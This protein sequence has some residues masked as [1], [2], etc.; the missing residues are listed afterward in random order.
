VEGQTSAVRQPG[1]TQSS[2]QIN[3]TS[4]SLR[5]PFTAP[6]LTRPSDILAADVARLRTE[7]PRAKVA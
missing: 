1:Q 2:F 4:R 3:S 6:A 7:T 5:P